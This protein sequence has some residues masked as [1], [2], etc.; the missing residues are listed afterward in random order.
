MASYTWI[1]SILWGACA[2]VAAVIGWR[3]VPPG[4][5]VAMF[6]VGA[7]CCAVA[8]HAY[9]DW[10]GTSPPDVR[11]AVGKIALNG[12]LG[13]GVAVATTAVA[14]A[15]GGV[16]V[17]LVLVA[18]L[19]SPW[20]IRTVRDRIKRLNE[21]SRPA[22]E[23]VTPPPGDRWVRVSMLP[24][25]AIEILSDHQLCK[26]WC[27]SFAALDNATTMAARLELV[28]LRQGYLDELER[29]HP[30]GL[31]AWLASGARAASSPTRFLSRDDTVGRRDVA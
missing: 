23:S 7:I 17:P 12:A 18:T 6:V 30:S 28:A 11:D 20:F 3:A 26:A 8:T 9:L 27:A 14:S 29:R 25:A 31:E 1:W 2:M 15:I 10:K 22:P 21:N 19:S 16:V 24:P 4:T 13:G 5:A